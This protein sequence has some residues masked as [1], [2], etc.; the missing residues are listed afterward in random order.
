[1]SESFENTLYHGDN[2]Q[3]LREYILDESVDSIYLDL[4]FNSNR[5]YDIL[6][7]DERGKHAEAQ[8]IVLKD[9]LELDALNTAIS[10]LWSEGAL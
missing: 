1:M 7:R 10:S 4:P 2:L 5:S 9:I 3:I 6:F 8:G